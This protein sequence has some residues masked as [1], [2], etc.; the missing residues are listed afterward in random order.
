MP[1]PAPLPPAVKKEPGNDG[2]QAS[3]EYQDPD[4]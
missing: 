4:A 2:Y 3:G 1:Q